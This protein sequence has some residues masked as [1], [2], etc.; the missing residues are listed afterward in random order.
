MGVP[1]EK[2]DEKH[3]DTAGQAPNFNAVA[4]YDYTYNNGGGRMACKNFRRIK[5]CLAKLKRRQAVFCIFL[6]DLIFGEEPNILNFR[7]TRRRPQPE[8]TLDVTRC[9]KGQIL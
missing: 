3:V 1:S 5:A 9:E 2:L 6:V 4:S 7:D 8:P